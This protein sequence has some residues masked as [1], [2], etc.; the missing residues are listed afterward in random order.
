VNPLK[1]QA[2]NYRLEILDNTPGDQTLDPDAG[3]KLTNVSTGD[4]YNS[5]QS[6]Q[7]LN[8]QL[9]LD[10]GL[11]VGIV[12]SIHPSP[13]VAGIG[14]GY[15]G[16]KIEYQ[17]DGNQ[18]FQAVTDDG[19][20]GQDFVS[21][22]LNTNIMETGVGEVDVTLDPNQVFRSV[23]QGYFYP[24]YMMRN[25]GDPGPP[26]WVSPGLA[27][28]NPFRSAFITH[29]VD[30]VRNV[31][32]VLTSKKE[33]WSK[34]IVVESSIPPYYQE[35]GLATKNGERN[36]ELRKDPSVNKEGVDDQ[37]GTVGYSYFP[38]YAL[39]PITGERLNIFFGENSSFSNDFGLDLPTN[40]GD[41]IWN[42]TDELFIGTGTTP[43]LLNFPLGGGHW[44]YVTGDPY[45]ECADYHSQLNGGTALNVARVASKVIWTSMAMVQFGEELNSIGDGLIP[46][47]VAIK[48]RVNDEY[49]VE[50]ATGDFNGYPTY[51]F[52]IG[53]EESVVTNN[54]AALEE[55]LDL[56]NAVP[57]PY[58]A[59]SPYEREQLDNIVKITNLPPDANITIYSLDGKFIRQYERNARVSNSGAA[60]KE[61]IVTSLDWDLKN[62]KGIPVS[63]GVYLI[64]VEVPNVG[65][66]VIKWF[67]I[68]RQFDASG[69]N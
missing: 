64:H 10:I 63:S 11:S 23:A 24:F 66:K 31:D 19:N 1:L 8:E 22:F 51:E 12:Q 27:D 44:I 53:G 29:K 30:N 14:N 33:D 47:D 62:F 41:M 69:L 17:N 56:I 34:C 9:L 5:E 6:I 18:W 46:N 4:V 16:S 55:A 40:G 25:N 3:W 35:N 61:Q 42:P 7:L 45:D 68:Q 54:A 59:Y 52:S 60:A 57:N 49:E 39:D 37:S 15:V 67:G 21:I 20:F 2:G 43:S 48:I 32:I 38:G 58:Y 50:V 28:E 36:F 13:A 26:W 65:E